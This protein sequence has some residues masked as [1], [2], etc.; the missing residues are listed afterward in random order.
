MRLNEM[1]VICIDDVEKLIYGLE[2]SKDRIDVTVAAIKNPTQNQEI[3][4]SEYVKRIKEISN[5]LKKYVELLGEDISD[6]K[7]SKEKVKETD[8][9]IKNIVSS[10][11]EMGERIIRE[12]TRN[13]VVSDVGAIGEKIIKKTTIKKIVS[14]VGARAEKNLT[15]E[16]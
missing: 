16:E 4:L 8:D 14:D 9:A 10:V 6:I 13:K 12:T 3:M 7:A 11:G 15:R 5:L 2:K 1:L